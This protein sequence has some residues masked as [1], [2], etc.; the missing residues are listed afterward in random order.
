M[1]TQVKVSDIRKIVD[2]IERIRWCDTRTDPNT[3]PKAFTG[4]LFIASPI[5]TDPVKR[6][7]FMFFYTSVWHLITRFTDR[8]YD[9]RISDEAD[10]D[11]DT[12]PKFSGE[13]LLIPFV[14][15][16]VTGA[17]GVLTISDLPAVIQN[18]GG[19][20]FELT[21]AE[22]NLLKSFFDGSYTP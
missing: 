4:N 15:D 16:F 14:P 9:L 21:L 6:Q 12:D 3:D 5:G 22:Q 19:Y 17:S 13:D 11:T 7:A 20:I 1:I 2:I 8:Y 18:G 10:P